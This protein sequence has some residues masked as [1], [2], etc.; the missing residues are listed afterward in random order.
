MSALD[1]SLGGC[2]MVHIGGMNHL[3][4]YELD[5]TVEDLSV[6]HQNGA[7]AAYELEFFSLPDEEGFVRG[8][9][10]GIRFDGV[11]MK[12]FDREQMDLLIADQVRRV[13]GCLQL[14]YDALTPVSYTHLDVYKRQASESL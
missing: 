2:A 11:K 7:R 6:A 14:G 12:A 1:R 9:S 3:D 10:A 8:P 13:R 5:T 4:K